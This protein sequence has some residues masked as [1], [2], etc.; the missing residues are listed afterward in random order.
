VFTRIIENQYI[1]N[2]TLIS[3]QTINQFTSIAS[4]TIN[5]IL[6]APSTYNIT[7]NPITLLTTITFAT[8]LPSASAIE[9]TGFCFTDANIIS[10]PHNYDSA[11][12]TSV[13]VQNNQLIVGSPNS[14]SAQSW[15]AG[16]TYLFA[17]DTAISGQKIIPIS[18]ITLN[19]N[20]FMING[21]AILRSGSNITAL[22]NDINTFSAYTG[23]SCYIS[24]ANLVLTINPNLYTSG[25]TTLGA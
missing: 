7:I 4:V 17:V 6:Q 10:A 16:A 22:V 8:S 20:P 2:S 25:I 18:D 15:N 23:V 1:F 12:G 14:R 24:N 13:A 11:F 19:N 5:G 21:W 3:V 9:I